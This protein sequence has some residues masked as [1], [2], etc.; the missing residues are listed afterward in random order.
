MQIC[1]ISFIFH[2]ITLHEC[3]ANFTFMQTLHIY[4]YIPCIEYVIIFGV[5][6][7]L[8]QPPHAYNI[9]LK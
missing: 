8:S 2:N 9:K 4:I 1:D 7:V 3:Y 5:L 6:T